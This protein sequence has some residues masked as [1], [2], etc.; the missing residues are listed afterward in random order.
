M[1]VC[2]FLWGHKF[3]LSS[4]VF[5]THCRYWPIPLSLL[6]RESRSF[7]DV[8]GSCVHSASS[9]DPWQQPGKLWHH[10]TITLLPPS[11]LCLSLWSFLTLGWDRNWQHHVVNVLLPGLFL[12]WLKDAEN[13]QRN[14]KCIRRV[15]RKFAKWIKLKQIQKCCELP[16][17]HFYWL[18]FLHIDC[19][20]YSEIHANCKCK[21]NVNIFYLFILFYFLITGQDI[22]HKN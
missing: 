4:I 12:L 13:S 15:Y 20:L 16:Y 5:V 18:C 11:W 21:I 3:C 7:T 1:S 6:H 8:R 14:I 17:I 9:W 2:V 22:D 19:V 10:L